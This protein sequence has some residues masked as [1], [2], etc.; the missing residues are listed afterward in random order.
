[1]RKTRDILRLKWEQGLSHREAARSLGISPSTVSKAV[2][3]A[4]L[5][6]LDWA[7][8]GGLSDEELEVRL[9]GPKLPFS[10]GRPVPDFQYL[11]RERRRPGVTL[12]LLHLEY[13]EQH[14]EDGYRY[15]RFCDLY[16]QW[17]K[18]QRVSMRQVHVAGEKLFVD[19]SGKKP[20]FVDPQT[21]EV[22]ECEFFVAVLGASNYTFAEATLSQR[23]PDWIGSHVRAFAFFGGV[24]KLVVSDQLKS[25]V[26]RSCRYEPGIQRTYQ[27]LAEH[28]DTAI[29]PARPY[30][31][32]DKAKAETGVQVAQR[33]ILARL[34]N[35]TFFSLEEL[36][37]RIDE[38]NDELNDRHM[39]AYGASR[40][41]LFEQLDRPALQPLPPERYVHGEWK[42]VGVNIDYHVEVDR[43]YYSVPHQ[44][45]GSK[46]EARATATT[47]EV[48]HKGRRVAA[49]RRSDARG[50][51][52]TTPEHMPK[53]HRAHLKW[54]PSRL[55]RWGEKVGPK[56]A[57]L[58]AAILES[59]P[60]P[61]QGYRSCLGILR[62]A[63]RY[64]EERLEL[65]CA[66]GLAVNARSYRHV[67]S[68]LKNGLDRL[69]MPTEPS[70]P[71]TLPLHE[72]VRGGDYYN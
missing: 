59:R 28:Y 5:A 52:T 72:N 69:P 47:V 66:R 71:P 7:T 1:M 34:R 57:A 61:E 68:I 8:V 38:L 9:Y 62:L 40:R 31:P 43:H 26:S 67:E 24:M 16:R 55:I 25:G 32:K 48:F 12:E 70:D 42:L 22:V 4:E 6:G 49:H 27:E 29:L 36:N 56:T 45:V 60:H 14:P 23:S 39:K 53:S 51:H 37:E 64:G 41:E 17:C 19:Y 21:G 44:L 18:K 50:R 35:D 13:L 2:H 63:K 10:R 3:R 15:S 54:S 30:K 33:W 58:V 65:A 46:L 11:H 20:H